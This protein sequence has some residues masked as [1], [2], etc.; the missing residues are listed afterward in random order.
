M[1]IL[2]ENSKKYKLRILQIIHKPQN[3]GAE[4]FA[5]QLSNHLKTQGHEVRV[6]AVYSGKADLPYKGEVI[7][8]D[9]SSSKR[10]LDWKAWY[11]LAGIINEFKPDIVQANAG[12]TLKYVV[13]SKLVYR[14]TAPIV[15]R[16]ASEVGRYLR[17]AVQKHL[18]AFFYKRIDRVISVSQA[19]QRDILKHFPFL[20]G[21]TDIIPV[22]LERK[23]HI[24]PADLQPSDNKH[25]VHVGGFSFEKNHQGL[26]RIFSK[27]LEAN[28]AVKLHLIGDGP[29]RGEIEGKVRE[30]KMSENIKFYGFRDNPLSYIKA[31]DVLVLPSIIEGLPGVLLEAMY[32]KTPVTAYDVGGISEIVNNNTGILVEK[33]EEEKFSE[34]IIKT[35]EKQEKNNI[36]E[37]YQMVIEHFMNDKL[38]L[39]F[40]NSYKKIVTDQQ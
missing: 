8:L 29:L 36:E 9:A 30:M 13:L 25:V 34:A 6:A 37:A 17:S 22:G 18:N 31:A 28:S 5:S 27:V 10:F 19:S 33:N 1:E 35:L 40:V 23:D 26:L 32:C 4:T 3:R 2:K 39:K 24:T 16:N 15:S 11:R 7:P 21:K 20:K 12:D 14:W 38:A